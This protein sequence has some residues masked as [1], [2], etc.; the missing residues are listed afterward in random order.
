MEKLVGTKK[1]YSRANVEA[2]VKETKR[3]MKNGKV[4]IRGWKRVSM[5]MI[6]TVIAINFVRIYQINT[7]I[8]L[9]LTGIR[10]SKEFCV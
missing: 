6:L 7:K 10:D 3:G 8:F 4:R 9:Y 5:H 1:R 2:T